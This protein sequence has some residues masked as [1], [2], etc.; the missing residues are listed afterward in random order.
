MTNAS[1]KVNKALVEVCN[2]YHDMIRVG[3]EILT[4]ATNV[5]DGK[6]K[7][8]Y[9][10]RAQVEQ[11]KEIYLQKLEEIRDILDKLKKDLELEIHL[12]KPTINIH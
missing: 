4:V 9:I 3:T 10:A 8:I 12:S 5:I 2:S 6:E 11:A 7:D 1:N